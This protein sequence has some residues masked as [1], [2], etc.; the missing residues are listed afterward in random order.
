MR[1]QASLLVAHGHPEAVSYPVGMMMDEAFVVHARLSEEAA[2]RATMMQAALATVPNMGVKPT[3]TDK[4]RTA[5][6]GLI[7]RLTGFADG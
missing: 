3:T 7:K 5:F 1:R 2:S 4:A 6:T